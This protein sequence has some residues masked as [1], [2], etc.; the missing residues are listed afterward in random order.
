MVFDIVG[1]DVYDNAPLHVLARVDA[2]GQ[3]R[4]RGVARAPNEGALYR[5]VSGTAQCADQ[6][7]D[8]VAGLTGLILEFVEVGVLQPTR[9]V[10]FL[11][12]DGRDIDAPGAYEVRLSWPGTD[13]E[14]VILR[15]FR[16]F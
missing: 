2:D 14:G 9:L 4:V 10:A 6:N 8:R 3:A 12:L 5:A 13:S 16:F 15:V 7:G 1:P 11:D